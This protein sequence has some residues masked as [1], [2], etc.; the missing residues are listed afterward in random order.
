MQAQRR[1]RDQTL[2]N[3]IER[4]HTYLSRSRAQSVTKIRKRTN[5]NHTRLA[6]TLAE[7]HTKNVETSTKKKPH[8]QTPSH[9]HHPSFSST[10][11]QTFYSTGECVCV[12]RFKT[13]SRELCAVGWFRF[14]KAMFCFI[15]LVG[16]MK[17]KSIA[18]ANL[19]ST[20]LNGLNWTH[21]QTRA[22]VWFPHFA[23]SDR[24]FVCAA[25]GFECVAELSV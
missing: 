12:C 18:S 6:Y 17:I 14:C 2:W 11:T 21:S 19:F 9:H 4:A 24:A 5:A 15:L 1:T 25:L 3:Q 16:F 20:Y 7:K 22:S 23:L 8:D 13:R 10:H